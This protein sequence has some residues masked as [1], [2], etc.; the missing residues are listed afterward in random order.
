MHRSHHQAVVTLGV[1]VVEVHAEQPAAAMDEMGGECRLLT[2]IERVREIHG[3][4]EVRRAGLGDGQQRGGGVTQQAVRAR[5]VR[6]VFDADLAVRIVLGDLANAVDL[7]V[8]SLACSPAGN[9]NRSRPGRA[10]RS[11]DRT[12][13]ARAASMPRLVSSI[14]SCLTDFSGFVKAPRLKPGWC[15]SAWPSH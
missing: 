10:R 11:S 7:P 2:G 12:P 8:P 4:A 9:C 15:S 3:D 13:M 14:A 6:L 1:A 5:L